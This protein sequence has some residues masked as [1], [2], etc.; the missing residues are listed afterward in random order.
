MS[1]LCEFSH[2]PE[3]KWLQQQNKVVVTP[4][5]KM[6]NKIFQSLPHLDSGDVKL[7]QNFFKNI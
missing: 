3:Q 2:L 6:S 7:F 4:L 1:Y 5:S